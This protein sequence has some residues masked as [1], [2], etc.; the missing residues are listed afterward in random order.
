MVSDI[1]LL[2]ELPDFIKNSAAAYI[3]CIS[4]ALMKEEYIAIIKAA[5]FRK[6]DITGEAV[7]PL[8]WLANDP[9]VQETIKAFEI[10]PEHIKDVANSVISI[11]VQAT[12]PNST[13][14]TSLRR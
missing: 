11:K 6:V 4:G 13:G 9:T 8:E 1:V 3:G 10:P 14:Q 2:K 5:G 12:K 7:F